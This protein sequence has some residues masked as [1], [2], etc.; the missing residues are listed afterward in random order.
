MFSTPKA[1]IYK[2]NTTYF[3]TRGSNFSVKLPSLAEDTNY[4]LKSAYVPL[5]KTLKHKLV[6][7]DLIYVANF[8]RHASEGSIMRWNV[9]RDIHYAILILITNTRLSCL[10]NLCTQTERLWRG[11]ETAS[12]HALHYARVV[13][14][15]RQCC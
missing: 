12:T 1:F 13:D 7:S 15:D 8:P 14:T 6:H 3:E 4:N 11:V 10:I 2:Q 9:S 5:N